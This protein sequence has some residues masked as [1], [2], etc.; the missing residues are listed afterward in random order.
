MSSFLLP[1]NENICL[2]DYLP[3]WF[4]LVFCLYFCLF[5]CLPATLHQSIYPSIIILISYF[6]RLSLSLFARGLLFIVHSSNQSINNFFLRFKKNFP[7]IF[8]LYFLPCLFCFLPSLS[9]S[10]HSSF[11]QSVCLNLYISIIWSVFSP[12]ACLFF[13][14]LIFQLVYQLVHMLFI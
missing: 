7:C 8:F 11:L 2:F 5:V 12:S 4:C 10:F 9:F 13:C 6:H 14:L 1:L 3:V